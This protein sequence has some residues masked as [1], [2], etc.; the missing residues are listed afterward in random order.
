[1]PS[2]PQN[3]GPVYGALI[4][5]RLEIQA[6]MPGVTQP[7]LAVLGGTASAGDWGRRVL[8]WSRSADELDL[9][10]GMRAAQARARAPQITLRERDPAREED[11]CRQLVA[12]AWQIGPELVELARGSVAVRLGGPSFPDRD[13]DAM[14]LRLHQLALPSLAKLSYRTGIASWPE[15]AALAACLDAD[16]AAL[17]GTG[18]Q[19]SSQIAHLPLSL[20]AATGCMEDDQDG[21]HRAGLLAEWG[22]TTF[23]DLARLRREDVEDRLGTTATPLWELARGRPAPQ[24]RLVEPVPTFLVKRDLEWPAETVERLSALFHDMADELA[25]QLRKIYRQAG[26]LGIEL[27]SSDS[28]RHRKEWQLHLPSSDLREAARRIDDHL[29]DWQ[30][31]AQVISLK[32]W[33]A[34]TAAND[35]PQAAPTLFGRG[36][37][38][39]LP[40]AEILRRIQAELPGGKVGRV[41]ADGSGEY[42]AFLLAPFDATPRRGEAELPHLGI[43]LRRFTK[44]IQARVRLAGSG[45][46]ARPIEL[47]SSVANGKIGAAHGPWIWSSRWWEG[48]WEGRVEWDVEVAGSYYSLARQRRG[49]WW[50]LGRYP[51]NLGIFTRPSALPP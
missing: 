15:M 30:G 31:G 48:E 47:R 51:A 12:V 3:T 1:M 32:L 22:I 20:A 24:R 23:G 39:P 21:P 7:P 41:V 44:K 25:I 50:L 27:A 11:L 42:G 10:R 38:D 45:P 36:M 26:T 16:G 18:Q 33:A 2:L 13:P 9:A 8:A 43:P 4:L 40:N 46:M 34:P 6:L 29:R 28:T 14:R 37:R 49:G 5:E 35:P 17:P 19:L